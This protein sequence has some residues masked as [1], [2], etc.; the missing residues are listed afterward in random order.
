M[1]KQTTIVVNGSLKV[2]GRYVPLTA[3]NTNKLEGY[4]NLNGICG[5]AFFFHDFIRKGLFPCVPQVI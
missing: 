4:L 5:I 2:N 3:K 1:T